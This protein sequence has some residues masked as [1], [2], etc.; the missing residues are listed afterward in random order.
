MRA[1]VRPITI[2][3]RT[4]TCGSGR[5]LPRAAG[6]LLDG[7]ADWNRWR[8]NVSDGRVRRLLEHHRLPGRGVID[9]LAQQLIVELVA[10]LVAAEFTDEAVTEKVEIAN[11][12]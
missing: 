9:Q 11:R 3:R 6:W 1:G 5:K 4:C 7:R 12:V 2:R 10:G 8:L